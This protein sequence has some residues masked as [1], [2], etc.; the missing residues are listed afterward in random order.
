MELCQD[1]SR[2]GMICGGM[3]FPQPRLVL[4]ICANAC[5]SFVPTPKANKNQAN[6]MMVRAESQDPRFNYPSL[7]TAVRSMFLPTPAARDF[8]DTPGMA[9]EVVINGDVERRRDDT[10]PRRIYGAASTAPIG[11]MRLT[12]EFLC[13]LMGY[14]PDWLKPLRAALATPSSRKPSSRYCRPSAKLSA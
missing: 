13:W 12:P 11:G 9:R 7:H 2:A 3:Y 4:A 1:W 10:L 6:T 5:C 14:P 8:K